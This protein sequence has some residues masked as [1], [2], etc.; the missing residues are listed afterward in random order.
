MITSPTIV[1]EALIDQYAKLVNDSAN[2]K[3]SIQEWH[4]AK[5]GRMT[6]VRLWCKG[7]KD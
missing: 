5:A 1:Y 2:Q 3:P 7:D 6:N 4:P